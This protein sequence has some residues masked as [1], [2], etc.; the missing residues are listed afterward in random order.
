MQTLMSPGSVFRSLLGL[1]LL[2]GAVAGL[3]AASATSPKDGDVREIL[4]TD[5]AFAKSAIGNNADLFAS[6]M[7]EGYVLLEFEPATAK[8][9]GHWVSTSKNEWVAAVRRGTQRYSAVELHDQLVH[10]QGSIATV[11]GQYSQTAVKDGKD[12]SSKGSY[13]ETWVKQNGRWLI[14]NSVF[15]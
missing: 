7:V 1:A 3:A 9:E 5:Q 8:A 6:Y 14:V 2:L 4:A 13:M 15:P 12:D 11:T 10:L